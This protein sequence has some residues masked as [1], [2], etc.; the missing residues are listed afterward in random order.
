MSDDTLRQVLVRV[1]RN[2]EWS[3]MGY[4]VAHQAIRRPVT[5][6]ANRG[7]EV[8][9]QTLDGLA[10]IG[11]NNDHPGKLSMEPLARDVGQVALKIERTT[12]L[13][14]L[15]VAAHRDE[16]VGMWTVECVPLVEWFRVSQRSDEEILRLAGVNPETGELLDVRP[17][18]QCQGRGTVGMAG[19]VE[20][21]SIPI[22][23]PSCLGSGQR[24]G[25]A[26]E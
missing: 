10:L 22:T 14:W 18:P 1:M 24:Q 2:G 5:F 25:M 15:P 20:M 3:E 8:S 12:E 9:P 11:E 19:S 13:L 16:L 26:H 6:R 7:G 23:C 21:G 4:T 17:C